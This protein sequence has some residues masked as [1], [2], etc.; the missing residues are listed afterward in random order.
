M[1]LSPDVVTRSLE[2]LREGG[3]PCP[4]CGTAS[5]HLF[6]H[7]DGPALEL[8][9]ARLDDSST[10]PAYMRHRVYCGKENRNFAVVYRPAPALPVCP[11]CE[12]DFDVVAAP[13]SPHFELT[14]TFVATAECA[15]CEEAL[16]DVTYEAFDVVDEGL[17]GD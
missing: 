12:S 9:E 4:F 6:P 13:P 17:R 2:R 11:S 14:S 15:A 8:L 5:E 7:E 16:G 1:K 3:M 10:D